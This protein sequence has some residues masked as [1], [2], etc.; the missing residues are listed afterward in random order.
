MEEPRSRGFD[1]FSGLPTQT[2]A[3]FALGKGEMPLTDTGALF[4]GP[5]YLQEH[6]DAGTPEDSISEP[7]SCS[8]RALLA[9]SNVIVSVPSL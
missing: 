7:E 3:A 9:S 6:F 5:R 4:T 8:A 1:I 2:S